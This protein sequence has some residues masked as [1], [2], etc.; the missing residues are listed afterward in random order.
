MANTY[1]CTSSISTISLFICQS[2]CNTINS[3][4]PGMQ[5]F[6]PESAEFLNLSIIIFRSDKSLLLG[7][8]LCLTDVNQHPWILLTRCQ[9]HSSLPVVTT[10]SI[11]RHCPSRAKLSLLE[12]H[13]ADVWP[14]AKSAIKC[15]LDGWMD[16]WTDQELNI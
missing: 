6:I 5:L 12:N 10:K 1:D 3:I 8:V 15:F 16:G 11:P 14:G 2:S 7:V 13:E 9:Q 4:W